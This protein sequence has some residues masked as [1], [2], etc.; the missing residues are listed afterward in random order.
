MLSDVFS[1]IKLFFFSNRYIFYISFIVMIFVYGI[2]IFTYKYGLDGPGHAR[3]NQNAYGY[4]YILKRYGLYI[5]EN[6]FPVLKY[7][8]VSQ[9]SSVFGVIVSALLLVYKRNLTIYEKGLFVILAMISTVI[10]YWQYFYFSVGYLFVILPLTVLVYELIVYSLR[11]KKLWLLVPATFM[12]GFLT[13]TI[14]VFVILLCTFAIWNILLDYTEKENIRENVTI[15]L[16]TFLLSILG[17]VLY[18]LS[19]YFISG[20]FKLY[21]TNYLPKISDGFDVL[22]ERLILVIDAI[23]GIG[24]FKVTYNWIFFFIYCLSFCIIAT[25]LKSLKKII[26]LFS[27][28]ILL[29]ISIFISIYVF[30]FQMRTHVSLIYFQSFCIGLFLLAIKDRKIFDVIF[31]VLVVCMVFINANLSNKLFNSHML[32]YEQDKVKATIILGD[33][34]KKYPGLLSGEGYSLYFIGKSDMVNLH[35]NLLVSEEIGMSFFSTGQNDRI[36]NFL[37]ILGL[38]LDVGMGNMT[39]GLYERTK[40]L[41]IWPHDKSIGIYGNTIYVKLGNS[42]SIVVPV[43]EKNTELDLN[44]NMYFSKNWSV[45]EGAFRW[46]LFNKSEIDIPI[47]NNENDINVEMKIFPYLNSKLENQNIKIIVGKEEYNF[48]M[49]REDGVYSFIVKK[50]N[51]RKS[52]LRIE[53]VLQN[54]VV[55]PA[56]EGYGDSR[57]LGYQI[58][59]LKYSIIEGEI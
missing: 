33:I 25:K 59:S 35:P 55:S 39:Y 30:N 6:I 10:I 17:I 54:E 1:K 3:W 29:L 56:M 4:F 53:T 38:P 46:S 42:D 45:S 14:A 16:V 7:H 24:T 9:I 57:K 43:L 34:Y 44:N 21:G 2:S 51:I 37:N 19:V 13:S 32:Q 49:N 27:L 18:L 40:N 22:Y 20:D 41:P 12:I 31:T 11:N 47:I 23:L 15:G 26:W 50:E 58:Y 48:N 8:I 28:Y 36:I 52:M 5:L